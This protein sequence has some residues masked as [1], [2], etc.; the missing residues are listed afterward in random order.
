MQYVNFESMSEEE[1]KAAGEALQK[2][3]AVSEKYFEK[4]SAWYE[5]DKK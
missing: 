1:M 2:V 5:K 3:Q 4:V